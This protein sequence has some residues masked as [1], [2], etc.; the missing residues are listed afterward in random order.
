M[1]ARGESHVSTEP[2]RTV[3]ADDEPLARE[4]LRVRLDR[5]PDFDLVGEA[6]D[7]EEAVD[8]IRTLRPDLVFLDIRMPGLDGF[9]VI[10]A[11]AGEF[12]PPVV[13]VSAYDD[14]AVRAFDV[15]AVD[16]LLKPFHQP[17]LDRTL[18][19]VRGRLRGESESEDA[20]SGVAPA[21]DP[22]GEAAGVGAG[23]DDGELRRLVV[24]HR[25]RYRL[26]AIETIDW[27]ESS[28]NY[29]RVHAGEDAFLVRSTMIEMESRLDP[30]RFVRIHRRR[31]VNVDRIAEILPEP[32]GDFEVVLASGTRLRMSRSH[33][34]NLLP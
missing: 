18:A 30:H 8:A 9:Q 2:I 27:I 17:R 4:I 29:V 34:T 28:G 21:E 3:V 15:H 23:P 24:H 11:L 1:V 20:G 6:G 32:Y 13:F 14:F 19:R 26:V 16:Y 5:E 12:L 33:R 25:G 22:G 7:G 31:I 10:E